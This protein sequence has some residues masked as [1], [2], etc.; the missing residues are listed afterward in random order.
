MVVAGDRLLAVGGVRN[1]G[2]KSVAVWESRDAISWRSVAAPKLLADS[3]AEAMAV[4]SDSIVVSGTLY[5]ERD[6]AQLESVPVTWR[7]RVLGS[8][9]PPTQEPASLSATEEPEPMPAQ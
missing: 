3:S 1:V 4:V 6:D 2:R 7:S 8:G 9:G 5:V